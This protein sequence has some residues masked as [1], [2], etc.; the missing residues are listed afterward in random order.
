MHFWV[1]TGGGL[2]VYLPPPFNSSPLAVNVK[3]SL[4][5]VAQI[6]V[7]YSIFMGGFFGRLIDRQSGARVP[8]LAN[9][10]LSAG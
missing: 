3:V 4:E 9:N 10:V 2:R 8:D 5:K 6:M 1:Q 7:N